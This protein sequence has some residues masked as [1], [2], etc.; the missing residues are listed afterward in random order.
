MRIRTVLMAVVGLWGAMVQAQPIPSQNALAGVYLGQYLRAVEASFP[1]VKLEQ[2]AK[3][4]WLAKGFAFPGAKGLVLIVRCPPAKVRQVY[5]VQLTG[6]PASGHPVFAGLRMGMQE[7]EVV[8]VLGQPSGRKA[9]EDDGESYVRLDFHDRNYSVEL[10][11]QDRMMSVMLWGYEG[12][13]NSP[14]R[15]P[16]LEDLKAALGAED[17]GLL[18]EAFMPD[19]E[20]DWGKD[21]LKVDRI[22]GETFGKDP[23]WRRALLGKGG[24]R[25]ALT[26]KDAVA[27]FQI[28][29]TTGEDGGKRVFMVCKFPRSPA[30]QEIV[31]AAHAGRW[32]VYE[33]TF[34]PPKGK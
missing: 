26:R 11:G 34:K 6:D 4:G 25:E 5:A 10:D 13:P 27:D 24:L 2:V 19:A 33:V 9:Y 3:D 17:P 15:L 7:A 12:F 31:F 22:P 29:L 8:R 20:L 28:R 21:L 14:E 18:A 30:L 32:R 1:E 23:A 16:T